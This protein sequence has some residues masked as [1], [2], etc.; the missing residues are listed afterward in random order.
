MGEREFNNPAEGKRLRGSLHGASLRSRD[1][2]EMR[3]IA[4][5][6]S[7]LPRIR[8][9]A[10]MTIGA[11]VVA[12][13]AC[14]SALA[15]GTLSYITSNP[16]A[17]RFHLST[18]TEAAPLFIHSSDYP[19]VARVA[20]HL[21]ADIAN[22]TGHELELIVGETASGNEIVLIGTLGKSPLI[23]QLVADK[24]LD[25]AEIA[26]QWEAFLAT[27]VDQPM[28]GVDRALVIV[29]SDKRGT[30]YGMYDLAAQIGVSPWHWW[31]DVPVKKQQLHS[32][33]P[34]RHV[35]ASPK[36]KYRG[37]FIND[38]APALS[39]WMQEKFGGHNHKFYDHVYQLILRLKG[40]YLWPA[41]WGRSLYDDDPES[42]KLADEYGIVIGTSHHE[43]MMRAH[44]EW[45]R[46]GKGK[47]SYAE[48][49]ATLREFWTEGV[50]RMG[51]NESVVTIGMRGDGDE[52]MSET[53]NIALLERIVA[54]QREIIA[55]VT[56]KH[57]A[58]VPQMWAL[59]KEV[60]EYY[61]RGMRVPDDVTLLLCD[62]N[63]G[64]I[65][66]LP[67]LDE[68]PRSGGYGIYYHFDYVGGPRNY[69]WLNTNSIPRIWEQM[70][71]AYEYGADCLWIV[72]VGD[73]KPMELPTE[74][75]L[76]YAWNP[77]A[78]PVERLGDYTR[79]WA[80]EQFGD[81]RAAQIADVLDKY[82]RYNA[83]RKP[84]LLGP[85]T[86]SL[87]NYREAETVVADY[88]SLVAEARQIG[89]ALPAEYQD[90]YFQLVLHPVEACAN[91]NELYLTVAKNRLYA[92][93]GRAATNALA[94][95]AH[96]LFENDAKISERYNREIAGGKWNHM[97]DQTHIGYTYWQEPPRNE[98]PKVE[99]IELPA[100]GALGVAVEGSE[101]CWPQAAADLQLPT[102]H[103]IDGGRVYFEVF[104]RGQ[105]P[106]TCEVV[107]DKPWLTVTAEPAAAE[108]DGS[109]AVELRYWVSVDWDQAPAGE[110]RV[111]IVVRGPEGATATVVAVI[112]N[113]VPQLPA[114]FRGHIATQG[115]AA[116]EA[117]RF[118][119]AVASAPIAWQIVPGLGR[120]LSGVM[121]TPVTAASQTPGGASPHLEY[122][123]W[124]TDEGPAKVHAY[125]SPTLNFHNDAGR[126]Y[127]ISIDDEPPQIVNI[128]DGENL[129]VWEKWVADNV[130][131]TTSEHQS[132]APGAHTLKFW[133][134]DPGLVL[135]RLVVDQGGVRSSYLG[136]PES[137]RWPKG[138]NQKKSQQFHVSATDTDS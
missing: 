110:R 34:G 97:M 38:E 46:Y 45:E 37:I 48:N 22:V 128:H 132:L 50:R 51:T 41:M 32:A 66:K 18:A 94:T 55:E 33:L 31:A 89:E 130:N 98:L 112:D 71:L 27:V 113:R 121:P 28:A 44:V 73:I 72:N 54:D 127:A 91:L 49:E 20:Q 76:D 114:D 19:G 14:T 21:Q 24:K 82:T 134:V 124:L 74:F 95:R 65:R 136:P 12:F 58:D 86:Y 6:C 120:T 122:R 103:A 67:K 117:E 75:F 42:P 102:L 39:G 125:I 87:T 123:F 59:Y 79:L 1:A 84:E 70:H 111:P 88:K 26:G 61:D 85:E 100:A 25:V 7:V 11:L 29:G 93:Q 2:V 133:M 30:I 109:L 135:Q 56:G 138:A 68:K 118:S 105:A 116:I 13:V 108:A 129:Q 90:A 69:K 9:T 15:V 62:D 101:E 64:N 16:S 78:W 96:E 80:A 107:T 3:L 83:R 36:V 92:K 43:P 126:R 23:D 17:G 81:E 106:L 131:V 8:K 35:Q 40:N 119:R 99:E 115:Y 47:W 60:Q 77:E 53:A 10:A 4:A 104:N 57:P 63:W 52:P 137:T 5:C